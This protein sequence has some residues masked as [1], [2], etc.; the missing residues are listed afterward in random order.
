VTFLICCFIFTRHFY[1]SGT[2]ALLS[3][4]WCPASMRVDFTLMI[5]EATAGPFVGRFR[6]WLGTRLNQS[7]R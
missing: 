1:K 6:F 7:P 2:R 3:E 5:D 4:S